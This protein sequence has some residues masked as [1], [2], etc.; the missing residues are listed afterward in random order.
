[1]HHRVGDT[2]SARLQYRLVR[3]ENCV[4]IFSLNAITNIYLEKHVY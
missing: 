2:H 3:G 4:V 1:M